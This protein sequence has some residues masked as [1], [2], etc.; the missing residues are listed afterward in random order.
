MSEK[1]TIT[2]LKIYLDTQET[3]IALQN[4]YLLRKGMFNIVDT[5]LGEWMGFLEKERPDPSKQRVGH[6][7]TIN[8]IKKMWL[9]NRDDITKYEKDSPHTKS[10]IYDINM[11]LNV[12]IDDALARMESNFIPW[13]KLVRSNEV[14]YN[15]TKT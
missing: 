14:K 2:P 4:D 3:E 6:L 8:V 9:E 7:D 1:N 13:S 11:K 12:N 5:E 10:G 15:R